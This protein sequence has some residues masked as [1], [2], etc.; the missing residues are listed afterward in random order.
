MA[1]ITDRDFRLLIRRIGGCG[2]VC[3]EFISSEG[4]TRQHPRTLRA[5]SLSAEEQPLAV[6][7]YGAD[8]A[9]MAASARIA[10]DLG[11]NVCDINMGCPARRVVRGCAGA[12]LAANLEQ[13]RAVIC[14]VRQAV[15]IPLTVKLRLGLSADRHTYIELGRLC[16][17][18]G[19]DAVTLHA[20]TAQQQYAGRADWQHIAR[21]KKS[22]T[23][24]VFGNGDVCSPSDAVRMRAETGCDAVMI[25][26]ASLSNPWIFQQSAALLKGLPVPEPSL[27]Q[28]HQLMAWHFEEVIAREDERTALHKLRKFTGWYTH[29]LA[30]GRSLRRRLSELGRASEVLAAVHEFF[31]ERSAA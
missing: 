31:A 11:A 30:E 27:G 3:M 17:D 21:L 29:G 26:R 1:G 23:I 4:L 25:G 24:P 19:V 7:I 22:L 15:R 6:Q 20:R 9:R 8:P 5:L 10:E 28:R 12:A 13:A 2:L 18:L 14:A 16:E